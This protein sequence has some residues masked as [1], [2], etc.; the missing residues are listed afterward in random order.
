MKEKH[1]FVI[2]LY[3]TDHPLSDRLSILIPKLNITVKIRRS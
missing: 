3:S 2:E 1:I